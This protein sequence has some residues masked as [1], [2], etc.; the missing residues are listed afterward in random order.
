[1]SIWQC[2]PRLLRH[3]VLSGKK[4]SVSVDLMTLTG[5]LKPPL[6]WEK[7]TDVFS[8]TLLWTDRHNN[9]VINHQCRLHT[10]SI[11]CIEKKNTCRVRCCQF[12]GWDVKT[13]AVALLCE[14]D[15]NW[16]FPSLTVSHPSLWTQ[17]HT[18]THSAVGDSGSR[19]VGLQGSED[20]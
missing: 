13:L 20:L 19:L 12:Y 10:E 14:V 3:T 15:V 2:T 4:K 16:V 5:P 17:V 7:F 6:V 1:M 9:C 8:P 18:E 11:C